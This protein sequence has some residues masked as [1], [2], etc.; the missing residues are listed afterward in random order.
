MSTLRAAIIIVRKDLKQRIRD[1]SAYIIGVIAPLGLALILSNSFGGIGEGDFSIGVGVVDQDGGEV[2]AE[3]VG[4]LEDLD[5]EGVINLTTMADID[6]AATSADDGDVAAALVIEEGFS[7][8]VTS[9]TGGALT[10][11]SNPNSPTG[12]EVVAAIA[13]GFGASVDATG[14]AI[15]TA[16]AL[17]A[18]P[19]EIPALSERAAQT[20]S[21]VELA[22]GEADGEA[23]D[24]TSYYAVGISVFFLFFTVQFGVLGLIEERD[25]G[26]LPRVLAAPI[27]PAAVILGKIGAAFVL[28]I[29]SMTAL[30]I[31]TSVLL[32]AEWGSPLPVAILTIAGVLAAMGIV[33]FVAGLV[34]TAQSASSVSSLVA[35][36]LGVLGGAFF[37]VTIGPKL[38][39]VASRLTPHRWLLDGYR[40]LSFG[41]GLGDIAVNI[42]AVLAFAVVAGGAG[43]VMSRRLVAR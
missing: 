35:V 43:L 6:E 2:A 1:R 33:S 17:G 5:A 28:G 41:E 20:T 14:A 38:L 7:A 9:G 39:D 25:N 42:V 29:V 23:F 12:T 11:I 40:D 16:V 37:P 36:V 8:A 34:K 21:P 13:R 24:F 10:V 19:A 32:G 31:A 3:F 18:S 30:I 27:S 15:A 4:A 22:F 26:T